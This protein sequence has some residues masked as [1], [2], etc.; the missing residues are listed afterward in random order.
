MNKIIV[1]IEKEILDLDYKFMALKL[2]SKKMWWQEINNIYNIW[3]RLKSRNLWK[4]VFPSINLTKKENKKI[5]LFS[6]PI[7]LLF[8]QFFKNREKRRYLC[9][10]RC[11]T[12][13]LHFWYSKGIK[14][15]FNSWNA[16]KS[17]NIFQDFLINKN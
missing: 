10:Q 16:N 17:K 13:F 14:N 8:Y 6:I 2:I 11:K 3:Q 12:I 5:L 9:Y 1:S 7:F 15:L 4:N